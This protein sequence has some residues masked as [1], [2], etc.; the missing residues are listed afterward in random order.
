LLRKCHVHCSITTA[1]LDESVTRILTG[2]FQA[3]VMDTFAK[4]KMAYHWSKHSHNVTSDAAATLARTLSA[5][6]TVCLW[7]YS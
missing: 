2:M 4:D 5:A 7:R 3:G 6:S 1:A